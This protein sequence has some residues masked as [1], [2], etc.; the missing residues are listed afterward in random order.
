MLIELSS[1]SGGMLLEK[2]GKS[3]CLKTYFMGFKRQLFKN[4][5]QFDQNFCDVVV[6]AKFVVKTGRYAPPGLF[7]FYGAAY[8]LFC[9]G[10]TF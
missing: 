1:W 2:F 10:L 9:E 5:S 4:L 8:R 7:P 3:V 6:A